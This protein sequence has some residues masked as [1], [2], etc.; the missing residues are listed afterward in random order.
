NHSIWHPGSCGEA[1]RGSARTTT[2]TMWYTRRAKR[3][4]SCSPS[5]YP[6]SSFRR[7]ALYHAKSR[8]RFLERG[9]GLSCAERAVLIVRSLTTT[10]AEEGTFCYTFCYVTRAAKTR[11]V[12]CR[13]PPPGKRS[14]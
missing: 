13:T 6:L 9:W 7:E 2:L 10:V 4:G 1:I 3:A 5:V 11:F 12:S 8:W 14:S